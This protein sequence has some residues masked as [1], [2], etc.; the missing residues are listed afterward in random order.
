[1]GA[2][3]A[4][5]MRP[6]ADPVG[7]HWLTFVRWTTIA[8]GVG[9]VTAAVQALELAVPIGL[10][11]GVFGVWILTNIWLTWTVGRMAASVGLAGSLVLVDVLVLT[12]LLYLAG[13]IL[14]PVSVFYLV[15]IVMA[16]LVLG[17]LWTWLV[18]AVA[19]GGY[20]SLYLVP[21]PELNAAVAMHREIGLHMRGM[22]LAFAVTAL[23]IALVVTRLAMAVERRDRALADLGARAARASRAAGLATLAAGAAHELGSPLSTIAVAARELEQRL[24]EGGAE[25][26]LQ[27]DAR[28]IRAETDRCRGVLDAMAGQSGQLIGEA[29]RPV[30]LGDVLASIRDRLSADERNRLDVEAPPRDVSLVWPLHVV[31]RAIGNVVQNAFDASPAGARVRLEARIED[32]SR[33]AMR[34]VDQG[35]GM[36]AV[37]LERVGDPFFTTKPAGKGTGLGIFVAR[38]TV[39]QLGGRLTFASSP[40]QGTTVRIALPVDVV[41][42][43]GHLHA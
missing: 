40:G 36:T 1:M 5:V 39:E 27:D 24:T 18:T 32:G 8:A 41:R 14:N 37:E 6:G 42:A 2:L 25:A 9:A 17:R 12:A 11:A 21:S 28:L 16:A 19:V 30:S 23:I 10:M 35:A 33:L 26:E 38:S 34:V 3:D 22:W 15:E 13:G 20:A 29:A 43:G 7:L 31:A 4:A